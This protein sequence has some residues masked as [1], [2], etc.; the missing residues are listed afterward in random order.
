MPL[1]L[2][3]VQPGEDREHRGRVQHVRIEMDFAERR[4]GAGNEL[5][6]DA[7]LVP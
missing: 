5:A 1:S 6:V 7:R 2:A 3:F 4:L